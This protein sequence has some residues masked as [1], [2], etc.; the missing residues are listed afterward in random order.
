M[1]GASW[2]EEPGG[3][4]EEPGENVEEPCCFACLCAVCVFARF[5]WLNDFVA[6]KR[7]ARGKRVLLCFFI[8]LPFL[9][10]SCCLTYECL[11]HLSAAFAQIRI[12]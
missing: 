11:P 9:V 1:K 3:N 12:Q 8:L 5:P 4:V 7:L 10:N 2:V 6:V